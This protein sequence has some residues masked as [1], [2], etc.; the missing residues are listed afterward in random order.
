MKPSSKLC[1]YWHQVRINPFIG[2]LL[3]GWAVFA[4]TMPLIGAGWFYAALLLWG[5]LWASLEHVAPRGWPHG[6]VRL[7]TPN[8]W[9]V[10]D[11]SGCWRIFQRRPERVRDCRLLLKDLLEEQYRLPAAL[12]PGLYRALTHDTILT[13]LKRMDNV[14]ILSSF[15]A[16]V[17]TLEET[18]NQAMG[19]RCRHCAER[20]PFPGRQTPR[21]FYDVRFLIK[22][23]ANGGVRK[24]G[25]G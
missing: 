12:E 4:L 6:W 22:E 16:Y 1:R 21:Q 3:A 5:A 17:A 20:C 8:F 2:P 24:T 13:R 14:A 15:P 25:P 23:E 19:K 18:V 10:R 11:F 7:L 9:A